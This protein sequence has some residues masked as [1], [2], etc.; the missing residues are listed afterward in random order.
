MIQIS[1]AF[2]KT[3]VSNIPLMISLSAIRTQLKTMREEGHN[4]ECKFQNIKIVIN[5]LHVSCIHEHPHICKCITWESQNETE[6]DVRL[7]LSDTNISIFIWFQITS[8]NSGTD[9]RHSTKEIEAHLSFRPESGMYEK[10]T[11]EG[12][13]CRMIRTYIRKLHNTKWC[14]VFMAKL[15]FSW[16]I[17]IVWEIYWLVFLTP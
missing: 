10:K 7:S 17:I 8:E 11:E 13:C 2:R 3:S 9:K 1:V 6:Q 16:S 5:T 14:G 4:C 15:L 12:I